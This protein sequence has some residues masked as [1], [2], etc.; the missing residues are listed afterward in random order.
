MTA[1]APLREIF[2][3]LQRPCDKFE[4]YF[5]LYERHLSHYIGRSPRILEIGVQYG[6]S[7]EMWRAWFGPGTTID[8]VDVNPLCDDTDYL[9]LHVGDQG[10]E[11]FWRAEFADQAGSYDIV[12]DDGSHDN[13]HQIE[14]LRS[15]YDLLKDGGV[16]WC[17]DTHTSYYHRVRVRD[18]GY[19][20]PR[21]FTEYAKNLVDVVN[22]HHTRH[23]IGVGDTPDGPHVPQDL[24][25]S[26]QLIQGVHFYDSV[27]VVEKG[28]R[29]AF[30]RTIRRG[31]A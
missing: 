7:A 13:P 1:V 2:E 12:I 27:V 6:G 14:T 15:T 28:R 31:R 4:H 20:N 21:S 19:G 11:E 30:E 18:G 26:Y 5:P 8:G 24:V 16:Y 9:R 29:L 25:S 3:K 22:E 17:E 23:A 10:S